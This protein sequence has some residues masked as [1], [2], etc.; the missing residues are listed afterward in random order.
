MKEIQ[1]RP[2]QK[3]EYFFLD[4]MLYLALYVPE[5]AEPFSKELLLLPEIAR[6]TKDFGKKNDFGLVALENEILVGAIWVRLFSESGKGFG[7]IDKHTPELSMAVNS[8]HR[9]LGI[10]KKLLLTLFAEL[11]THDVK[12]ISLSVDKRNGAFQLY[13]KLD[14]RIMKEAGNSI[15]MVKT[16][17]IL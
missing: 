7:W 17:L 5:G 4:E 12:K 9:G 1:I 10:G 16:L 3:K 8:S 11:K 13:K 15:T 14:F 6:Y 2:I